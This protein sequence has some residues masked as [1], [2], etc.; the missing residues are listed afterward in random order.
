MLVWNDIS[1]VCTQACLGFSIRMISSTKFDEKWC[2]KGSFY[3]GTHQL[4]NY[5]YYLPKIS[6]SLPIIMYYFIARNT[7]THTHTRAHN[8]M[9]AVRCVYL[10]LLLLLFS[11]FSFITFPFHPISHNEYI[12]KANEHKYAFYRKKYMISR[13]LCPHNLISSDIGQW[14]INNTYSHMNAFAVA[15]TKKTQTNP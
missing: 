14:W 2:M 13:F 11:L 9:R 12:T 15:R 10:L 8:S 4:S 5:V 7:H 6:I 1:L 3:H